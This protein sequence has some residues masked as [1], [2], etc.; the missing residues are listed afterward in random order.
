MKVLASLVN[1]IARGNRVNNYR[2]W[3]LIDRYTALKEEMYNAGLW[4]GWCEKQGFCPTHDAY[5]NFA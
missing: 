3:D 5:D 4:K 1:H 2:S